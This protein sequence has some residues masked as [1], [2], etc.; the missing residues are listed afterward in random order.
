[1][2]GWNPHW[3]LA[4]DDDVPMEQLRRWLDERL[5]GYTAACEEAKRRG[6][7]VSLVANQYRRTQSQATLVGWAMM[8]AYHSGVAFFSPGNISTAPV[9]AETAPEAR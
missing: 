9:P 6:A 3:K 5:P 2:I 1:M 7:M 4:A 8:Y